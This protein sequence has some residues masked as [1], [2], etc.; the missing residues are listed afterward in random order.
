MGPRVKIV[1]GRECD[2]ALRGF[3]IEDFEEHVPSAVQ[4]NGERIADRRA[5]TSGISSLLMTG[6]RTAGLGRRSSGEGPSSTPIDHAGGMPASRWY[7]NGQ[8]RR[9]RRLTLALG[10]RPAPTSVLRKNAR[11]SGRDAGSSTSLG[12]TMTMVHSDA[13]RPPFNTAA[14][15]TL[16]A[17]ADRFH[18]VTAYSRIPM[19]HRVNRKRGSIGLANSARSSMRSTQRPL[20][21]C[22]SQAVTSSQPTRAMSR[23]ATTG[24]RG[25]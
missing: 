14:P 16:A 8:R 12:S 1:A 6:L 9:P 18:R 4:A 25:S 10:Y 23:Q 13:K 20:R 17:P 22:V 11:I 2:L 21:A 15:S 24:D 19:M 5:R 3:R 7:P